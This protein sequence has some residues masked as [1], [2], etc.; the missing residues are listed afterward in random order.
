MEL[1]Q[2]IAHG[3]D[4]MRRKGSSRVTYSMCL[5]VS[6][7]KRLIFVLAHLSKD[8]HLYT[9]APYQPREPKQ[10]GKL[11]FAG[12]ARLE[13]HQEGADQS[14]THRNTLESTDIKTKQK[15]KKS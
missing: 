5:S 7:I 13:E 6:L 12:R 3:Q 15:A 4:S 8:T 2:D 14:H 1:R 11:K 10:M 9:R